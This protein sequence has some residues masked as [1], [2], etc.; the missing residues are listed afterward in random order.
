MFLFS[1]D[2]NLFELGYLSNFL[3]D[4]NNF[5]CLFEEINAIYEIIDY[6]KLSEK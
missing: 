3:L 2:K 1:T 6:F 4:L 5:N